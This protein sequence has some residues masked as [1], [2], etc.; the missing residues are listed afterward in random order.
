MVT[1]ASTADLAVILVDAKRGVQ[2]QSKRHAFIAS[3]LGIAHVV[4]AVNK[5]DLVDYSEE[6]FDQI[7]DEFS[8]FAGKLDL[9]DIDFIPVSAL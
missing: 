5:M 6:V 7:V 2:T 9:R 8:A 4:V 3:L 1:G